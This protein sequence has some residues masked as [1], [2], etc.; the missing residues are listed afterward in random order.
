MTDAAAQ[1][2]GSAFLGLVRFAR[3]EQGRDAFEAMLDDAGPAAQEVF[4]SRIRATHWYPYAALAEFLQGLEAHFGTG[5]GG[6]CRRLGEH[7]AGVDLNTTFSF[8]VRLYGPE[9]LVKA[10]GRVW[11]Q[12]YKN[13]GKMFAERS[14]PDDT[15]VV[16][17]GFPG[18][19][20]EHCKLMEG[21]MIASMRTIGAEVLDDAHERACMSEGGPRHEFWCR[22]RR[23]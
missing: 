4:A 3:N 13:A 8:F 19:A 6:Y 18:M 12:Y 10:C 22:W 17:E 2:R 21:W 23:L 7:A 16:I 20:K 5:D 14:S 1:A 11:S 9:R 15:L